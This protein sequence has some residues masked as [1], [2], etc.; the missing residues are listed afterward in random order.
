MT[1]GSPN[2]IKADHVAGERPAE[3]RSVVAWCRRDLDRWSGAASRSHSR[4]DIGKMII[5]QI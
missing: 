2:P 3:R 4:A 5:D 1:S